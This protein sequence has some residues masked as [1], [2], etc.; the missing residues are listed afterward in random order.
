M[1]ALK[2]ER[3]HY[4]TKDLG[5]AGGYTACHPG[6]ERTPKSSSGHNPQPGC[7]DFNLGR[8]NRMRIGFGS[9]PN[10]GA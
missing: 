7:S 10:V 9:R 3:D 8:V 5:G 4:K 1:S 2:P 6:K